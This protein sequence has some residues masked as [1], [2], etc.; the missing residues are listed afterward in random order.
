MNR[1]IAN[2]L[3]I[4][5]ILMVGVIGWAFW[6]WGSAAPNLEPTLTGVNATLAKINQGCAPGPCGPI[7]G[8]VKLE[9]KVGDAVVTTQLQER[10]IAPAVAAKV[11]MTMDSLA[12]IPEHVNLTA[13]AGTSALSQAAVDLTSLNVTI[14]A[15]TP[16]ILNAGD[17]VEDIDGFI[18]RTSPILT[19]VDS[20]SASGAGIMANGKTVSDKITYDFTHP[21]PWY[22]QPGKIITLG[23]DAALLAK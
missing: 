13:D 18:R 1:W 14:K 17:A 9:T 15:T 19:N 22:K 7:D 20:M 11:N 5:L 23:F 16:L 6:R 12:T 3:G 21:V 2:A 4:A 10:Q 8:A